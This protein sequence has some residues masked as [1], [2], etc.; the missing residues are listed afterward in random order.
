MALDE[1]ER[2]QVD[3]AQRVGQ[4][5]Q[6]EERID[7]E[8]ARLIDLDQDRPAEQQRADDEANRNQPEE[9]RAQLHG[10]PVSLLIRSKMG[11]YIAITIPPT[12]PPSTAIMTGS[13]SVSRPATA[14]STSSS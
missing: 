9:A 4:T 2:R 8:R 7:G 6:E 10:Y 1:A 3:D 5:D 11:M 14:T 13:S 12:T